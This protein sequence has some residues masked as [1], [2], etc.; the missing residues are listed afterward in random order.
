MFSF[1]FFKRERKIDPFDFLLIQA[2][3]SFFLQLSFNIFPFSFF[4]NGFTTCELTRKVTL[5]VWGKKAEFSNFILFFIYFH[6]TCRSRLESFSRNGP[7]KINSKKKEFSKIYLTRNWV[8]TC[9]QL[10][11]GVIPFFS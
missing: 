10:P 3:K 9:V 7:S 8:R 2:G 6:A 11:G 4:P 1:F 5:P